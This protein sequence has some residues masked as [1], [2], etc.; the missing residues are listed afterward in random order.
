MEFNNNNELHKH[1][2]MDSR[3]VQKVNLVKK[4]YST[5]NKHC[6]QW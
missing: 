3:H 1:Q 6:Y 2:G 4:E 5:K